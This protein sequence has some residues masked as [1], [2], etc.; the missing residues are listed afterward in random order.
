[1]FVFTPGDFKLYFSMWFSYKDQAEHLLQLFRGSGSRPF[2]IIAW[3]P[4]LFKPTQIQVTWHCKSSCT[5]MDPK[6]YSVISETLWLLADVWFWVCICHHF[7][8]D[9]IS[10]GTIM[11]DLCLQDSCVSLIMSEV[12]S[13]TSLVSICASHC[14]T[15]AI[16]Y[17]LSLSF[18]IL[19]ARK[20]L[21]MF[22]WI[23]V[24]NPPLDALCG[25]MGLAT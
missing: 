4:S 7:L 18:Y 2:M 15:V 25:Y 17:A 3:C 20:I 23:D 12:W 13:I 1:M 11:V 10:K 22:G 5:S 8:V 6:T 16:V 21:K 19:H 24:V 14:M 9:D